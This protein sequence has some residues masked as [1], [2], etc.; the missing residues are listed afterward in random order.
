[1]ILLFIV[2]NFLL[3]VVCMKMSFDCDA[4]ERAIRISFASRFRFILK[5]FVVIL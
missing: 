3:R 5:Y 4:R 2:C 1:M